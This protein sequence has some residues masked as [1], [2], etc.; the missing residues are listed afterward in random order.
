MNLATIDA[1]GKH[2]KDFEKYFKNTDLFELFHYDAEA[3]KESCDTLQL[4]L[5]RDGFPIEETPTN[6]KHV[7]FLRQINELV[8]GITLNTNLYTNKATGDNNSEQTELLP[9]QVDSDPE[10][11][12]FDPT[13]KSASASDFSAGLRTTYQRKKPTIEPIAMSNL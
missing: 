7:A 12:S 6:N 5:E 3:S 10:E 8:K 4:L 1:G 2:E 13:G 9:K 11:S